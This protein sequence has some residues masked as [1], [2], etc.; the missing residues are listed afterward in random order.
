MFGYTITT[1]ARVGAAGYVSEGTSVTTEGDAGLGPLR[2][3][4]S[5]SLTNLRAFGN[6]PGVCMGDVV[7]S[8]R[9]YQPHISSQ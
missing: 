4:I 7:V 6:I 1:T 9:H 3:P 2:H 8:L 5:S